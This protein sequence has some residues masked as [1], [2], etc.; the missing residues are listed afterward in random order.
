MT[1]AHR[2][3][4]SVCLSKKFDA[5]TR[6]FAIL[7]LVSRREAENAYAALRHNHLL[8][9]HLVLEWAE[10]LEQ[11]LDVPRTSAGIGFGE[12]LGGNASWIWARLGRTMWRSWRS[13]EGGRRSTSKAWMI[14]VDEGND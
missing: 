9:R 13:E 14:D 6:G 7:D 8:G 2:H 5:R 1:S 3:L 11:D 10:E 4:K 12:C